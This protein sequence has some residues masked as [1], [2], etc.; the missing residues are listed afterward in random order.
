MPQQEDGQGRWRVRTCP[1][2]G[3]VFRF[4]IAL[5]K[6]RKYCKPS[7]RRGAK[8]DREALKAA[9][10]ALCNK[11][12]GRRI[13]NRQG[14]CEACYYYERRTGRSGPAPRHIR[15]GSYKTKGGYV[16]VTV[17][18]GHE[19][20]SGDG[21]VYEHRLVAYQRHHKGDPLECYWCSKQLD[22]WA[23]VVV[24]HKNED[25]ADNQPGNVVIACNNCNRARGAM[26]PFFSRLRADRFNEL[27][28]CMRSWKS[29]NGPLTVGPVMDSHQS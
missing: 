24:D 5:G 9:T 16:R 17:E 20:R 23:S 14:I 6:D 11:G 19:L 2:C 15:V 10:S 27:L 28:E 18:V 13:G 4:L 26:L 21:M 8:K 1:R 25:K 7:C 22:N 3:E 12:C 29:K